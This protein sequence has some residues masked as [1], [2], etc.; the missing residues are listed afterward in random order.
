MNQG[1]LHM[2]KTPM[3]A[4]DSV[5]KLVQ[6]GDLAR[7]LNT[8]KTVPGAANPFVAAQQGSA[9]FSKVQSNGTNPVN[10]SASKPK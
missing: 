4:N 2:T 5:C 6:H 1:E 8:L 10:G 3:M 9:T 7:S